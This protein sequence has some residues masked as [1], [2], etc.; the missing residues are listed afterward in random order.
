MGLAGDGLADAFA[1]SDVAGF[2]LQRARGVTTIAVN[3]IAREAF[4]APFAGGSE[5]LFVGATALSIAVVVLT[6]GALRIDCARRTGDC[7]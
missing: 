4:V 7:R 1:A 6:D 5:L 3:T 2:A